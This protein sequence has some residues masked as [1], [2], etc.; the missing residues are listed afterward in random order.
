MS[1]VNILPVKESDMK[2]LSEVALKAYTDHYLYLWCDDGRWYIQKCF[3]EGALKKE[4]EDANARLFIVCENEKPIGFLKLNVDAP[5][6]GAEQKNGLELERIYLAKAATGKGVGET[7]LKF[8]F[9]FAKAQN[10]NMVWLKVMD[11]SSGPIAFY[12]KMGFETCGT[13]RLDFQVMKEELRGMYVMKREL[14]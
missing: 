1:G 7:I 10:K 5:L 9:Q 13:H 4:W 6:P 3:S 11:S 12:K 8:V 2:L 14:N